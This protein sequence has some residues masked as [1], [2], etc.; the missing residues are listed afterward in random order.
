LFEISKGKPV[1]PTTPLK[2]AKEV[3]KE[4]IVAEKV[5]T[6]EPPKE[7]LVESTEEPIVE[8]TNETPVVPENTENGESNNNEDELIL[9]KDDEFEEIDKI[10]NSE[11]TASQEESKNDVESDAN[12]EDSLNLTIG[13]EEEQLLRDDDDIKP[14]GKF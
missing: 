10:G 8:S 3:E 5:E 13:E 1:K 2:Q 14:K 11:P 9:L 6:E 12:I 7:E 4:P